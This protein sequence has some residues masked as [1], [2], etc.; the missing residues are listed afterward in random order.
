[1]LPRNLPEDINVEQLLAYFEKG[2]CRVSFEGLHKRN[3]YKDIIDAKEERDGTLSLAVGRNSLYNS[4]PEYL[5]HPFERF[6]GT[7]TREDRKRF[8]EEYQKQEQERDDAYRFFAPV[9]RILLQ[10]RVLVREHLQTYAATDKVLTDILSDRLTDRQ[11]SNRFIRQV[12]PF[13]P[14]FKTIRGDKTLLSLMLRKVFME[15][16]LMIDR[17][18]CLVTYTDDSPHYADGPG[19]TL[20]DTYVGNTF[21]EQTTIYDIHYWSDD[22]CDEHF[23]QFV[24]DVEVFQAFIQDYLMSV[25]ETIRFN[26]YKD[27]TSLILSD[28]MYFNYLNYNTNL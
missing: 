26:I 20:G 18:K 25:E 3:S 17:H 6:A 21:D 15:E 1:M 24:D 9:D 27:E 5:F 23:L 11:R 22:D 16:G 28:N 12:L 10:L 14:S 13:F 8:D 4:L 2:S 7:A 19:D